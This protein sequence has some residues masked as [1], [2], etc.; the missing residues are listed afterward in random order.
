MDQPS[1]LSMAAQAL[2]AYSFTRSVMSMNRPSGPYFFSWFALMEQRKKA[3]GKEDVVPV[4]SRTPSFSFISPELA[5]STQ[6]MWIPVASS[7]SFQHFMPSQ[8]SW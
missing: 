7:S 8:S 6:L 1:I 4:P 3:S 2:G 5:Y